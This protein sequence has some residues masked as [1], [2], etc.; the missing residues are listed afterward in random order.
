M[1]PKPWLLGKT[2]DELTEIAIELGMRRFIGAQLAEWLYKKKVDSFDKMTNLSAKFRA[3][4]A[5][6]YDVGGFQPSTTQ[7]SL[8]FT[9]KY[10]FPSLI[11]GEIETVYIP[12][13]DRATLCISSQRGCRM[14]CKFC[15]TGRMG[16]HHNLN[17]G[18]IIGQILRTPKTDEIT[19][20]VLMGM[21]EPLDNPA[22]FKA[23]EIMTAAWGFAWSPTRITLSTI[24]VIPA[25]EKFLN[26]TKVHLAISLHNPI[27]S[28]RETMMPAQRKNN[29]SQIIAMLKKYDFAHQRRLSFEYI[30]FNEI[31][32]TPEHLAELIKMLKPLDCRVNLIRF[33]AIPN[34]DYKGSPHSKIQEFNQAL[35]HAGIRTTTRSSRGEDI[36]AACGMLAN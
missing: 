12:D 35:N 25:L 15:M 22:V 17:A 33:H 32:D 1:T 28:E 18:E 7:T 10:L 4:I 9:E 34:S 14:R 2:V 26:E 6:K 20:V 11:G 36:F 13:K 23:L 27:E 29:I 30:M 31:N 5:E 8:D 21:G 16:F 19:N 24:G 3:V